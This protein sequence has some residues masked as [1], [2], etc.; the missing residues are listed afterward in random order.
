M[1]HIKFDQDWPTGLK[2]YSCLKC[3]YKEFFG[4]SRAHNSKVTNPIRP[5]LITSKFDEDPI[6][7]ECASLETPFSHYKFMG[8]FLDSQRHV[9]PKRVIR[10]EQNLNL[11]KILCLPLLSASLTQIKSKLKALA[12][13]HCFPHYVSMG[14][15]CCHGNHSFDGI[16]YKT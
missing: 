6:K 1:L 15:F 9:T 16:C 2:R 3:K 13:R 5:V 11:S 12:W 4:C 10:S 7:N 8:N 14:A